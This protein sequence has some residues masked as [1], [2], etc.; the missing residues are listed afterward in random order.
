MGRPNLLRHRANPKSDFFRTGGRPAPGARGGLIAA[1]VSEDIDLQGLA[2]LVET[3]KY[4]PYWRFFGK[5]IVILE[6][7]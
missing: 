3:G 5:M 4:G 6:N 1:L 7:N 2:G